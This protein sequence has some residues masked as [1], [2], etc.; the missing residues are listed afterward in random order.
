MYTLTEVLTGTINILERIQIPVAMI[1]QI[2]APILTAINNL[3][4]CVKAIDESKNKDGV[5]ADGN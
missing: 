5:V 2:G 4:E 1:D 3:T